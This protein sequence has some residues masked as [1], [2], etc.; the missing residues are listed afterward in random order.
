MSE[1]HFYTGSY[2]SREL[3]LLIK[4]KYSNSAGKK[5]QKMVINEDFLEDK[6]IIHVLFYESLLCAM[7]KIRRSLLEKKLYDSQIYSASQHLLSQFCLKILEENYPL[8]RLQKIN[9]IYSSGEKISLKNSLRINEWHIIRMTEEL[10]YR[11]MV[12]NIVQKYLEYECAQEDLISTIMREEMIPRSYAT[13]CASLIRWCRESM[14]VDLSRNGEQI[15]F[16]Y[17]KL[18]TNGKFNKEHFHTY[19]ENQEMRDFFD[20]IH[21]PLPEA[22]VDHFFSLKKVTQEQQPVV[23]KTFPYDAK[24]TYWLGLGKSSSGRD[25]NHPEG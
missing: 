5:W 20:R 23:K 3:K 21:Q 10:D 14:Q 11:L 9:F 1:Y 12:E 8:A 17:Y 15:Y 22:R 16:E 24:R 6:K 18:Y 7:R 2:L 19:D 25:E 4:S 13:P